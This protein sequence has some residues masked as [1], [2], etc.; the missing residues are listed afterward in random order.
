MAEHVAHLGQRER[1]RLAR[2]LAVLV[3]VAALEADGLQPLV[4]GLAALDGD[5]QGLRLALPGSVANAKLAVTVALGDAVDVE[6]VRVALV[7]ARGVVVRG[8]VPELGQSFAEGDEARVVVPF[9]VRHSTSLAKPL[10]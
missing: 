1:L 5:H 10:A 6:R 8:V 3:P 7:V 9:L 4:D 2:D